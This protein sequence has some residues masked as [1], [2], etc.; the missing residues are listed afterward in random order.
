MIKFF[1]NIRK[2]LLA[3]GK[4]ANY[5]KYAIGEIILVV[6]GILIALSVNNLN[7]SKNLHKKELLLLK[8]LKSDL[9]A[10]IKRLINDD[11]IYA[12]KNFQTTIGIDLFYKAKSIKDI[13]TINKLTSAYWSALYIN[14]NT[15]LEMINTGSLYNLKNKILQE[16]IIEYYVMV[17][18]DKNFINEINLEQAFL[19]N[20]SPNFY[21][22]KFLVNQLK[23]PKIDIKLIDTSWINNPNSEVY[24][25]VENYLNA[26]QSGNQIYRRI[27]YKRI[28]STANKLLADI[29]TYL[30]EQYVK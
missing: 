1:R 14:D 15:Y 11:S 3:Q 18:A 6:I 28:L 19:Y 27:I 8:N 21:P 29:D 26:Q 12:V 22:Y 24:L 10:D 16:K 7:E 2:S 30:K 13:D 25:A 23:E 9:N 5:I 17:N 4:T 20:K